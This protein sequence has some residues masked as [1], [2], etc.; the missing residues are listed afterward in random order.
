MVCF[1]LDNDNRSVSQRDVDLIFS[2]HSMAI[3]RCSLSGPLFL[4]M[5][6]CSL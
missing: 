5:D 1:S 4:C 6:H 3:G 2:P